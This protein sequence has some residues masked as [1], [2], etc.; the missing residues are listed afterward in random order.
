MARSTDTARL[1]E[2]LGAIQTPSLWGTLQ[3]IGGVQR[4][5]PGAALVVTGRR[6][7]AIGSAPGQWE[8]LAKSIPSGTPPG[9]TAPPATTA[10]VPT[11]PGTTTTGTTTTPAP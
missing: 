11:T 3:F 6:L 7:V 4:K 10:V 2:A 1:A 9:A 5:V 8:V